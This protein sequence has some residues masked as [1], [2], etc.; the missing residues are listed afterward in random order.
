MINSLRLALLLILYMTLLTSTHAD[1]LLNQPA[2]KVDTE[3]IGGK[4]LTAKELEGKVVLVV[5]WATWCPACA[6]ELP[7]L[8]RLYDAAHDKGLEILA[9]SV[10]PKAEDA[11]VFWKEKGYTFP[12]GMRAGIVRQA[13]GTV[14]YTPQLILV[15]REGIVR[16]KFVG[17]MKYEQ[18]EAEVM[19]LL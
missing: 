13:W 11:A 12:L 16:M 1:P 7:Q 10:D 3:L 4:L 5:F 2:P 17:A 14:R 8:Q 6:K 9:L 15:D 18:L 19:P